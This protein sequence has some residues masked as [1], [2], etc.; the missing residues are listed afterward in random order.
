MATPPHPATSAGRGKAAAIA[1]GALL[2]TLA[3]GCGGADPQQL[4]DDW[5]EAMLSWSPDGTMLLCSVGLSD[6]DVGQLVVIE[7][8]N[9]RAP[10]V[11]SAAASGWGR[12]SPDGQEVLHT[13]HDKDRSDLRL[14]VAKSDGSQARVLNIEGVSIAYEASWS[15][16]GAEIAFAAPSGSWDPD[17]PATMDED[18]WVTRADG[19]RAR[20]VVSSPGND[21]WPPAWSPDG[22]YLLYTADGGESADADK[23]EIAAVDL[24]TGTITTLTSNVVDD[25]SP[26]WRSGG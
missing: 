11:V 23:G 16:D 13:A 26:D 5:D 14:W 25:M 6:E 15:P 9:A 18:I 12:W 1:G 8:D 3:A 24:A 4:T 7:S 17:D 21:H 10:R 2:T 22:R 20:K 19:A